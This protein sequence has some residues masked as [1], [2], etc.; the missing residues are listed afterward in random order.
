MR[1]SELTDWSKCWEEMKRWDCSRCSFRDYSS[2]SKRG[3]PSISFLGGRERRLEPLGVLSQMDERWWNGWETCWI[4]LFIYTYCIILYCMMYMYLY[5][6]SFH[7][8]IYVD[9]VYG[10]YWNHG[11][12]LLWNSLGTLSIYLGGLAADTLLIPYHLTVF[13]RTVAL[14]LGMCLCSTTEVP[15][16][17]HSCDISYISL[18]FP[19]FPWRESPRPPKNMS[20][21]LTAR[22]WKSMV[23]VDDISF[24]KVSTYF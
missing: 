11:S 23:G 7:I 16:R 1:Y 14:K 2:R 15:K 19:C 3:P 12:F 24:G 8:C 18:I 9:A 4:P 17:V 10:D 21:K 6:T 13:R 22:P 5:N 20:L